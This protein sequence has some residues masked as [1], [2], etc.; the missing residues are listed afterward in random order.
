M[1]SVSRNKI[2]WIHIHHFRKLKDIRIDIGE[3]ITVIAGHNGIGKSTIL[4]L[5]A[6]GS[7]LKGYQSYFDKIFQSQF[8]EIFH[9]DIN[10][11]YSTDKEKKYSVLL[12]Y[13]Y[14][15]SSLYKKCN[16]SKHGDRLKIVPRNAKEDG[17]LIRE[18]IADVRADAKVPIPTLYIGMSRVIPIGESDKNLYSLTTSS[19]INQDD[20]LYLNYAYKQ[21]IGDERL[22]DDKVT[23]QNLKHSTKRS[24]GPEFVDYP[25]QSVSLGQDSL[26]SILTAII[27]FKKL[28]REMGEQYKGGILV[29]DEIDACLHPSAQERLIRVIDEAA[30]KFDLQII[31]TSHSLTVI[32]EIM[33]RKIQ[34]GQNP[35]D[36]KL[37]YNVIYL[38]NTMDPK[39]MRDPNY[40]KIKNDMFLRFTDFYDSKQQVKIYLE[41]KEAQF[42]FDSIIKSIT[43]KINLDGIRIDRISANISCD[44]LLKLPSKDTYFKSVIIITD[45]DVKRRSS[46]NR[47]IT[48]N[49]N[50][51]ALPGDKSPEEIIHAYLEEL[52]NNP[53]HAFWMD[54]QEFLHSQLVRDNMLREI[55]S[56]LENASDKKRREWYKIW[57]QEH[58]NIFDKTKIISYWMKDNEDDVTDFVFQFNIALD[59]MRSHYLQYDY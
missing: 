40:K 13:E 30:K 36:G 56:Q 44:T 33:G 15:N 3:R 45:G 58:Q 31:C 18:I 25:Y 26:S 16:V 11:D 46:Y 29:I 22:T 14:N 19:N 57:F 21:I 49:E 4:G 28:K 2:N 34:T 59:Y 43:D 5:I 41:D 23:K 47:I 1:A 52:V 7:E 35:A 6:N 54:N 10:N 50:I 27:S 9:L 48:K 39:V 37:Y 38:Q 20:I 51:V 8:Q 55:N 17:V 32:K 53:D 24:I 12:S 42:F